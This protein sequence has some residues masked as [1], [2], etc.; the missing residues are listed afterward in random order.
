M[1]SEDATDV[2]RFAGGRATVLWVY[3]L[4]LKA[5]AVSATNPER[6]ER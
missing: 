3:L 1:M 5:E 6:P 2:Q 4:R